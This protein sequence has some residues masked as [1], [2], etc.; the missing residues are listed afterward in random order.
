MSVPI[1]D[2]LTEDDLGS[3]I[4]KCLSQS[5]FLQLANSEIDPSL[6]STVFHQSRSFFAGSDELKERCLYRSAAENF[7]FQGLHE[8]NLNPSAPADL[9]ATFTMRN[10]LRNPAPDDRWP[11]RRFRQVM[12]EFF[13]KTLIFSHKIMEEMAHYFDL[14][15]SFF[16]RVHRG[17]T[18]TLRLLHYPLITGEPLLPG[19]LGAGAHTDYG[20]LT[21]L[22]Q[23]GVEGLQVKDKASVWTNVP[24]NNGA[25]TMNSG[26]LLEHWTNGRYQSTE[27]RVAPVTQGVDRFSIAMFIDPDP[28]TLVSVL[29]ACQ[30]RENPPRY[31]PILARDHVQNKLAASHKGRFSS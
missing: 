21:L 7:G 24:A 10:I 30:S 26:D 27:H 19:Q 2:C 13:E 15:S 8:E 28:E 4:D 3:A 17:E 5:G 22:F 20:F 12:Q 25:I 16:S 14:E 31:K 18:I 9:K 6:V 29:D 11:S 23:D 1:I